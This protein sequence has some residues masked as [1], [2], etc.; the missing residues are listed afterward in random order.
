MVGQVQDDF[1][2]LANLH[3][4]HDPTRCNCHS[5]RYQIEC[6][7]RRSHRKYHIDRPWYW[8]SEG[9][10]RAFVRRAEH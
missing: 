10:H 1:S 6:V 8:R 3:R 4:W 5:S 7:I 2:L 9:L